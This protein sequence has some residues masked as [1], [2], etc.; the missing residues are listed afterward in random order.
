[1]TPDATRT[2]LERLLNIF[3]EVRHG[4]AMSALLLALNIFLILTAY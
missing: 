1:M 2:P 4:E 3:T